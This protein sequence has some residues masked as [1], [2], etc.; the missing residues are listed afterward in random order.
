VKVYRIAKTKYINDLSGAGA[1]LHGG[2]WNHI[3]HGIIYTS[4]SRALAT[5]E[6][7]VHIPISLLPTDCSV[8]TIEITSGII[9]EQILPS[10]LPSNWSS[11][12]PPIELAELGTVWA[13]KNNSLLLRVPS[14]AVAGDFNI[15]I[16]TLHP[17]MKHVTISNIEKY[18]YDERLFK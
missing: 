15:L 11:I 17:D 7:V 16:N 6:Y 10:D 18:E 5:V 2:R 13:L 9:P 3:G 4:E 14:A 8:A 12:P 1:K